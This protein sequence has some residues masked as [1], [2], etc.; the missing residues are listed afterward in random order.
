MGR[1]WRLLSLSSDRAG[2]TPIN[3]SSLIA[4]PF[5]ILAYTLFIRS[6]RSGANM[7]FGLSRERLGWLLGRHRSSASDFGLPTD[8]DHGQSVARRRNASAATPISATPRIAICQNASGLVSSCRWQRRV[9]VSFTGHRPIY[10]RRNYRLSNWP[11]PGMA[12][13]T[14]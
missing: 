1:A 7:I 2:P 11:L 8:I 3:S 9:L 12:S 13:S 10:R 6:S 14:S 4:S 5:K